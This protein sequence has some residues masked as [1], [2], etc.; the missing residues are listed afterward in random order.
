MIIGAAV[1]LV[2]LI[3]GVVSLVGR[4]HQ[5]SLTDQV[6]LTV[7]GP[8]S[9]TLGS[10]VVY[11]VQ[12]SNDSGTTLTNTQLIVIYPEGFSFTSAEPAAT[13]PQG[14]EPSAER[15][16]R[17]QGLQ[18]AHQR[19]RLTGGVQTGAA[20]HRTADVLTRRDSPER[21]QI[22]STAT[23]TIGTAAFTFNVDGPETSLPSNP[24]TFD[25]ELQNNQQQPLEQL[26]VR[27]TYAGGF[28]FQKSTPTPTGREQR[29]DLYHARRRPAA[30][31]SLTGVLGG[32]PDEVK[33][34]VFAAG[35]VDKDG[36]F[37]G[38]AEACAISRAHHAVRHGHPDGQCCH[39]AGG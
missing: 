36:N 8:A 14:T 3:V 18:P 20:L 38:E 21:L 19:R 9:V 1:L 26:Q 22:E 28:E 25:V 27:A 4:S 31:I 6:H 23:T 7:T 34:F 5:G 24:V 32:L 29:L 2:L 11:D 33:R 15:H 16:Q 13:N 39:G 35:V 37:L 12:V 10:D 30:K 17:R